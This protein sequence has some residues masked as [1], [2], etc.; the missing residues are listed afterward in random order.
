MIAPLDFQKAKH[1][2]KQLKVTSHRYPVMLPK[3]DKYWSLHV[4]PH[5]EK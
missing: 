3:R 5:Q 4:P 1:V 2:I